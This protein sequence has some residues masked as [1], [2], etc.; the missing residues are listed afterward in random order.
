M[1][2]GYIMKIVF[3]DFELKED[4]IKVILDGGLTCS[5]YLKRP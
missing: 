3:N 2:L 4:I 5:K 1:I